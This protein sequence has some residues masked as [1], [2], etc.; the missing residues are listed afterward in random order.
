MSRSRKQKIFFFFSLFSFNHYWEMPPLL[1]GYFKIEQ[2]SK[3]SF[4]ILELFL[5]EEQ[6]DSSGP[7]VV[8]SLSG[9]MVGVL[10]RG[11][12]SSE[13]S[14]A[15]ACYL[16]EGCVSTHR[17]QLWVQ[18]RGYCSCDLTTCVSEVVVSIDTTLHSSS[19]LKKKN[20]YTK[21]RSTETAWY[22]MNYTTKMH[23]IHD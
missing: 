18:R 14:K 1:I 6:A 17:V 9:N 3:E 8:Y 11:R 12:G 7:W 22:K 4:S 20:C 2:R 16:S 19:W 15:V 10:R 5:L 13:E 23:I 21:L